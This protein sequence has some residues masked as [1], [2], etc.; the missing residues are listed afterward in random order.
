LIELDLRNP[1]LAEHFGLSSAKGVSAFLGGQEYGIEELLQSSG[2]NK[3]L[4][5]MPAGNLPLNPNELLQSDRLDQLIAVLRK[6]YDYI[7]LDSAPVA[8]VS[9]T[10]VANRVSDMTVM[11]ARVDETT[12]DMTT[13][14][15]SLAEQNRLNNM[16]CVLNAVEREDLPYGHSYGYARK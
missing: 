10:F 6:Q 15:N 5:I 12:I 14:A 16:V 3:N 4:D 7:I 2:R 13:Y 11:V 9:D 1:S 8:M